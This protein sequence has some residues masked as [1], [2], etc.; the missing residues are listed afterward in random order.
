MKVI[1]TAMG[2]DGKQIRN[3]GDEFD[4]PD[5]SKGSWFAPLLQGDTDKPAEKPAKGKKGGEDLT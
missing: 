1:A 2:F 5:E 4:M 3:P